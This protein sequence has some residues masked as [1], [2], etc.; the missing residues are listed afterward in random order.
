[1]NKRS[2][3]SITNPKVSNKKRISQPQIVNGSNK[4]FSSQM[5]K[6]AHGTQNSPNVNRKTQSIIQ[7]K[8][9]IDARISHQGKK[10]MAIARAFQMP[11]RI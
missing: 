3:P 1:M 6:P 11:E 7:S 8:A 5:K 2:Q 9:A 4:M 10:T